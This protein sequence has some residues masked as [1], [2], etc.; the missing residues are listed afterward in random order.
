[1]LLTA[2]R[3]SGGS[4]RYRSLP[5]TT[6]HRHHR[7]RLKAPATNVEL[8]SPRC[9]IQTFIATS[10]P[11][12]TKVLTR[13]P[14]CL[15]LCAGT[16]QPLQPMQPTL[17]EEFASSDAEHETLRANGSPGRS[18]HS[19]LFSCDRATCRQRAA[20]QCCCS[21]QSGGARDRSPRR[22]PASPSSR[23]SQESRANPHTRCGQAARQRHIVWCSQTSGY[24]SGRNCRCLGKHPRST[25]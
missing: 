5:A 18:T 11:L 4:P 8:A 10:H 24:W 2:W 22:R 15:C 14:V 3:L 6:N 17:H 20:S 23:P 13:L 16:H 1:M 7:L 21:D 19:R 9:A 25:L 12:T